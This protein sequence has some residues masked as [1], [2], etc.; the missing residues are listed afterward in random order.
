MSFINNIISFIENGI[1]VTLGIYNIHLINLFLSN[2]Q[3]SIIYCIGPCDDSIKKLYG[4]RIVFINKTS[5]DALKFIPDNIDI[6]YINRDDD[7]YDDLNMYYSKIRADG[8][9]IGNN[10]NEKESNEV[11]KAYNKFLKSRNGKEFI[12]KTCIIENQFIIQKL[13]HKGIFS[14]IYE[15]NGWGNDQNAL[16]KGS[17]GEGSTIEN[18][19]H[20]W[21]PFLRKFIYENEIHSVT[22]LG[23]GSFVFGKYIYDDINIQ[24][25]GYD[26]YEEF[27][28][29]YAYSKYK[30]KCMDFFMH[31]EEIAPADLCILKDVL[32]HW[33]ITDITSFLDY[34]METNKF[35][36][37]LICN[38]SAQKIDNDDILTGQ[39][40]ALSATMFP[41]K[42]YRP[43]ILYTYIESGHFP[44]EV[45]LLRPK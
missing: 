43:E 22:D 28:E 15:I 23:C 34:L 16:Y 6:L 39:W 25:Q 30:F 11:M 24:Y 36:Y 3:I 1:I 5:K 7:I 37:I 33:T 38:G 12:I 42:K 41:L 8:F 20:T 40:R 10:A 14:Y 35:K 45:S 27:K 13:S 29:I 18:N 44:K 21:V 32:C 2:N 17:S 19:I 31:K 9:V 26:A 4:D